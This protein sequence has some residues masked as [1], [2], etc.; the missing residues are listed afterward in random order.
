MR[1]LRTLGLALGFVAVAAVLHQHGAPL[2]AW[3]ALACNAFLW[4]QVAYLAACHSRDPV[5]AER[6][7]LVA[8]SAAGGVWIAL[9]GFNVLPSVLLATM[10]AMDKLAAGG[11]RLLAVTLAA[12]AS[13]CAAAVAAFGFELR[14]ET[15]MTT[16]LACLPLIVVYPLTVGVA[17]YRLARRVRAQN[18]ELAALSRTDGLSQ[19]LNRSAWEDLASAELARSRRSGRPVSLLMIDV[20]HFKPINDRHGHRVGDDVI[21]NVA[22]LLREAIRLPDAVGRYGGEEFGVVLPDTAGERAA[23]IAERIRA[24][25]ERSVVEPRTGLRCTVSIGVAEAAA[26]IA[27]ACE[28]IERADRALY[29]AKAVGR[30]RV[31]RHGA[32]GGNG[33]A[34]VG[35]AR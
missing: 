32:I 14:P 29:R 30:N 33:L 21:R 4:P 9:M 35:G 31:V 15:T 28:W 8:D 11:P 34:V 3:L 22:A 26:D 13:A 19:L 1:G 25:V 2:A 27:D 7:N 16:V 12:Q 20:D 10:L 17:S 18:R 23:A 24:L 6:V 5:R